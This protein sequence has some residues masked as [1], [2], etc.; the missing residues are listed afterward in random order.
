ML[1][2]DLVPW[3]NKGG[4]DNNA[5]YIINN[6]EVINGEDG[7]KS[8]EL[9]ANLDACLSD[10]SNIAKMRNVFDARIIG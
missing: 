2:P 7:Y 3:K 8:S 6:K 1:H 9:I 5:V 10:D 4:N